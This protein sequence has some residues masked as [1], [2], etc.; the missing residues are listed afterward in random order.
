[1]DLNDNFVAQFLRCGDSLFGI[2]CGL[3]ARDPES[4]RREDRFALILV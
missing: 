4:I 2:C 3:T 1:L